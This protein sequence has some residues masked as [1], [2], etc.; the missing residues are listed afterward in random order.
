[1][2]RSF[3]ETTYLLATTLILVIDVDDPHLGEYLE[4]PGRHM[5]PAGGRALAPPD[6]IT[7]MV[8]RADETGSLTKATN[9]AAKRVWGDDVII[10]HV[11]DD[12]LFRTGGWD[13]TMAE[14]LRDPGI[15]YGN[16]L[17]VRELLPTAPFISSIIPRTLG[18][19]ALPACNHMFIDNAWKEL[20]KGLGQLRYVN[21]VIIEHMHPTV[22]KSSMDDGYIK[23]IASWGADETGFDLWRMQQLDLDLE[24]LRLALASDRP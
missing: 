10:G 24:K 15:A 12:H 3:R 4:I 19:Y 11:G 17:N 23:A 16:D 7:I 8:L 21:G 9:S 14:V 20:G 1:M 22:K 18:W 5:K 13:R 2:V 6:A